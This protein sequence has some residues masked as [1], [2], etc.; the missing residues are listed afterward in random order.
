MGVQKLRRPRRSVLRGL[1]CGTHAQQ[2]QQ[3]VM[4]I[5]EYDKPMLDAITDSE[6]QERNRDTL[7]GFYGMLKGAQDHLRFVFLTGITRFEHLNIFSGLNNLHDILVNAD[8]ASL[9]GITEAELHGQLA[10]VVA[11]MAARRGMTLDACYEAL[12]EKYDGYQFSLKSME[13]IYNPFSLLWALADREFGSYWFSNATPLY[14][15]QVMQESGFWVDDLTEVEVTVEDL[16]SIRDPFNN[17]QA[18]FYQSGYLT[19]GARDEKTGKFRLRFPNGEVRAGCERF[20]KDV[21]LPGKFGNATYNVAAFVSR[22]KKGDAEG[23]MELLD[24]LFRM[25]GYS[26]VGGAGK[27]LPERATHAVFAHGGSHCG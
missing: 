19:L 23:F 16:M 15:G 26:V 17:P 9:C 2:G 1:F 18:L 27:V 3:V 21:Y 8:Y 12:R 20:L 22:L 7:R 10:E 6:L 11:E 25:G 14:L 5:D 4:L 13:G 24:G